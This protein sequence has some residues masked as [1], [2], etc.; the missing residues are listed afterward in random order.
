VL[1]VP[2]FAIGDTFMKA[3]AARG[4]ASV[5][6]LLLVSAPISLARADEDEPLPSNAPT[7][8]YELSAW[9]FGAMS[10]YLSIYDQVKPDLRAIDKLWGSS[11]PNEAEPYAA[12]I[13]AARKELKVLAGA[14]E[15]AEKASPQV[16]S[17]RGAEAVRMGRGIWGPA[18]T[19]TH[20]ELARAWLSWALPDR[21]DSNA[22][23]L[24]AKSLLLGQVLKYN[25]PS[26]TDAPPADAAPAP[27]PAP[28]TAKPPP[29]TPDAAAVPTAPAAPAAPTTA[30]PPSAPE[31]APDT[32][33]P[34]PAAQ[35]SPVAP[36][37]PTT[38][39]P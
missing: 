36:A 10:E 20:R 38:G 2:P 13:A 32:A 1:Y 19:G 31:P 29:A 5:L 39:Q 8:P 11:V 26:A 33:K 3:H 4:A 30:T 27:T 7:Q 35:A 18:E 21:C 24:T 12:D 23:E 14:V 34:P 17:P 28:D 6:S 9:C 37:A 25:A 16:I 15:A 22:R